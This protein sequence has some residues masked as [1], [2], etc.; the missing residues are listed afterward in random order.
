MK[1]IGV[2]KMVRGDS[3]LEP[4]D[5]TLMANDRVKGHDLKMIPAQRT[6]GFREDL[7]KDREAFWR[8]LFSA[9]DAI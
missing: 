1:E 7:V 9:M 3:G 4:L 8:R 6:Y 2:P 5:R